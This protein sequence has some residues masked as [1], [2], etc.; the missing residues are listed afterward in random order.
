MLREVVT[1][2]IGPFVFSTVNET[3]KGRYREQVP[4]SRGTLLQRN[5]MSGKCFVRVFCVEPMEERM[6]IKGGRQG[7]HSKGSGTE[8]LAFAVQSKTPTTGAHKDA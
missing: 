4:N 7:I 6:I 3:R 5:T 2:W 1:L 8:P